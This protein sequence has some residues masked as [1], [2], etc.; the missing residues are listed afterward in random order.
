MRSG[1]I[2]HACHARFT[3]AGRDSSLAYL[4]GKERFKKLMERLKKEREEFEGEGESS[5][6]E[7]EP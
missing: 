7:I 1:K 4:R 3:I 2:T 5:H 6:Q